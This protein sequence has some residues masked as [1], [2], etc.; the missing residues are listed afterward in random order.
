MPLSHETDPTFNRPDQLRSIDLPQNLLPADR[1]ASTREFDPQV[2][3]F[4]N[5]IYVMTKLVTQ[6]ANTLRAPSLPGIKNDDL[7]N[8]NTKM[9]RAPWNTPIDRNESDVEHSFHLEHV[10]IT[11]AA[12]Y[13]PEIDLSL[14]QQNAH[15]HDFPELYGGDTN[16]LI[17]NETDLARKIA[18]EKLAIDGLKNQLSSFWLGKLMNYEKLTAKDALEQDYAR[19]EFG[20]DEWRAANFVCM[21]DKLLPEA[22]AKIYLDQ[23]DMADFREQRRV[24]YGLFM[25]D[26]NARCLDAVFTRFQARFSGILRENPPFAIIP[27]AM[28]FMQWTTINSLREQGFDRQ[29]VLF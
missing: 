19:L 23:V 20:N 27:A 7:L 5:D 29:P 18:N 1:F 13:F 28:D 4:A 9:P 2:K 12:K 22:N 16:T 25:S 6:Y 3:Y 24:V 26:D 10:A 17:A 21:I 11:L 14:V 15:V 8:H